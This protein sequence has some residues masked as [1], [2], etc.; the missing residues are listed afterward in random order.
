MIEMVY[1]GVGGDDGT[2]GFSRVRGQPTPKGYAGSTT[3]ILILRIRM[4]REWIK[5]FTGRFP[6][7]I[8]TKG[9]KAKA[10]QGSFTAF[11]MTTEGVERFTWAGF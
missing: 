7:G 11:R 3:E 2:G 4:T 9:A 10:I 6:S 5:W 8:K 1:L